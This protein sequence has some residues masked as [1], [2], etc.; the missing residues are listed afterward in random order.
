MDGP[1]KLNCIKTTVLIVI[2]ITL[3]ECLEICSIPRSVMAGVFTVCSDTNY[4]SECPRGYTHCTRRESKDSNNSCSICM[5]SEHLHHKEYYEIVECFHS[6]KPT[7]KIVALGEDRLVDCLKKGRTE[8]MKDTWDKLKKEHRVAEVTRR[9]KEGYSTYLFKA[10]NTLGYECS[11]SFQDCEDKMDL[12]DFKELSDCMDC[13]CPQ[14]LSLTGKG[15]EEEE[16]KKEKNEEVISGFSVKDTITVTMA[17]LGGGLLIVFITQIVICMRMKRVRKT[18][19]V[20]AN[21]EYGL[22]SESEYVTE[23]VDGNENYATTELYERGTTEIK[24]NNIY[25]E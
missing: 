4:C 10:E 8:S 7:T 3:T 18:N 6:P 24:D 17:C 5:N 21:P 22:Y 1:M 23:I 12:D 19:P 13:Q 25:Y 11:H 15:D 16:K 14:G 2:N 20:E 9:I